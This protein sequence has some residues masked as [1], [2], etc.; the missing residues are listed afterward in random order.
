MR[1]LLSSFLILA[2]L[3]GTV[4]AAD[5]MSISGER[6]QAAP[7]DII[8]YAVS[9]TNNTGVAGFLVYVQC[10][11]DVFSLVK[12]DDGEYTVSSSDFSRSGTVMANRYGE[13]GWQI[14]W[15]NAQ[16]VKTN[17]TLFT[18]QMKVREGAAS[19]SY[20]IHISYS[21]KDT[22]T[23]DG[24]Q[25]PLAC[26]DGS[27]E[28]QGM[29]A[30]KADS[31]TPVQN[32][33]DGRTGAFP[34]VPKTHWAYLYIQGLAEKKI[35]SGDRSGRFHPES[36]VT[37]AQFVKMLAGVM[38]ADL[39]NYAG[40]KFSD[41]SDGSWAAPYIA[42][43]AE[44]GIVNGTG[45]TTF[46]P[47]APITREQIAATVQRCAEG[48]GIALRADADEKAFTDQSQ[49]SGYAQAAVSQM[50]QAG[51]LGGY[52]DG[53]FRPKN[54]ANRAEAAKIL[55]GIFEIVLEGKK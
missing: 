37:R 32:G 17:G 3:A 41:V 18:L 35:V 14:L 26:V 29:P 36:S 22:V 39:S 19:G 34:D 50:A 40:T 24:V 30:G 12:D 43:A 33:A 4:L 11:T 28:V 10:D 45:E 21:P 55:A 48:F 2:V 5:T 53:T 20:P 1:K 54:S 9:I 31:E 46:S 47:D 44:N 8:T 15:F 51:I 7:G 13:D 49:I 23:E 27:V 38:G 42:W 52:A 6:T 25:T 16:N